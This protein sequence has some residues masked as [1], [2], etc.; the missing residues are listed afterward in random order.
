MC[1]PSDVVS[2]RHF[3]LDEITGPLGMAATNKYNIRGL[4]QELRRGLSRIHGDGS[5]L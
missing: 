2:F 4:R 5:R 3:V 1:L